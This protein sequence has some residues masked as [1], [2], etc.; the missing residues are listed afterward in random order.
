MIIISIA[1]GIILGFKIIESPKRMID[2]MMMVHLCLFVIS[3]GIVVTVNRTFIQHQDFIYIDTKRAHPLT[4]FM[5]MGM[6]GNGGY[7]RPDGAM[8]DKIKSPVARNQANVR[9]IQD[10]FRNFNGLT[11]YGKFLVQKQ[12]NNTADGTFGWGQEGTFL[13]LNN[14]DNTKLNR[15]FIRKMFANQGTVQANE[16]FEYHFIVQLAWCSTLIGLIGVVNLHSWKIQFLKYSVVGF[17][18]FLLLFEGGRSRYV[19]QFLPI[20]LI[21]TSVG[22]TRILMRI[23][24]NN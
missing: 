7:Y 6:H 4:H 3:A 20:V 17:M 14:P 5:A 23:W 19:I 21:L 9:L 12:I 16:N 1:L 15:S 24:R 13:Q 22:S 11:N 18:L 8:D 2:R 10:R